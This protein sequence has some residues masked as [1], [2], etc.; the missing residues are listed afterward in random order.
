VNGRR[1]LV[2]AGN[3]GVETFLAAIKDLKLSDGSGAIGG[4][5]EMRRCF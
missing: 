3:M 2:I 1:W 4:A 5:F